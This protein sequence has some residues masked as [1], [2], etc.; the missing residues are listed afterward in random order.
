MPCLQ[1]RW[2]TLSSLGE[3]TPPATSH[4][5]QLH[6][7]TIPVKFAFFD[8]SPLVGGWTTH[9]KNMLVKLDHFSKFSGCKFQ[10][11]LSC[12]HYHTFYYQPG[13]RQRTTFTPNKFTSLHITCQLQAGMLE[14]W[15]FA[16]NIRMISL[17]IYHGCFSCTIGFLWVFFPIPYGFS[18]CHRVQ[19]SKVV[20]SVSLVF[21]LVF[22]C[23]AVPRVE[24]PMRLLQT[25][26]PPTVMSLNVI[27]P[28]VSSSAGS[29]HH[30]LFLG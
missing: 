19:P 20:F 22:F 11:S 28:E 30:P 29:G 16:K 21:C 26:S 7:P 9:L 17:Q 3:S 6:K 2:Q 10:K 18:L 15:L 12:H 5:L 24:K 8:N 25:Y 13:I 27:N 14:S 4:K 23:L 1:K